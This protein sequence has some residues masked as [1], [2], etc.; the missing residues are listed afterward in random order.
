MGNS[1]VYGRTEKGG[2]PLAM[3]GLT[4]PYR[5]FLALIDG[6]RSMAELATV[7]RP[8]ELDRTIDYLVQNGYI[9]KVS[10]AT[11]PEFSIT[12]LNDPFSQAALT[13]DMFLE[14][15]N[16]IVDEMLEKFGEHLRPLAERID[17]C[18]TPQDLRICLRTVESGVEWVELA[19]LR[20]FLQRVGRNLV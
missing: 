3:T 11:L 10:E 15:K 5:R 17:A 4:Q 1:F 12:N 13:E 14:L 7:A 2:D 6:I 18:G 19:E 8:N 9:S 16:R 20:Q